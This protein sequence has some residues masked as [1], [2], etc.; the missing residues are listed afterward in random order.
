MSQS[1]VE[2]DWV[3]CLN[4]QPIP[5]V[6]YYD[7]DHLRK[8]QRG[9]KYLVTGLLEHEAGLGLY[10]DDLGPNNRGGGYLATRF[11]LYK[12]K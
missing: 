3:V 10:L 5:G 8:L 7:P 4:N 11:K 2:G 1:F 6:A 12:E 9:K